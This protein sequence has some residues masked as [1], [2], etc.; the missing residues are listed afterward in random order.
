MAKLNIALMY[1][2]QSKLDKAE[3]LAVEVVK[4]LAQVLGG[5]TSDTLTAKNNLASIYEE[6]DKR[7]QASGSLYPDPGGTP[8]R[9]RRRASA[10]AQFDEQPGLL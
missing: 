2:Q 10:H 3:P 7:D 4:Q 1:K 8:P 6:N 9:A 5:G